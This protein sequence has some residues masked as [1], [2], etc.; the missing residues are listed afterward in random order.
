VERDS[1]TTCALSEEGE[2][3]FFFFLSFLFFFFPYTFTHIYDLNELE[4][5]GQDGKSHMGNNRMRERLAWNGVNQG[6][7]RALAFVFFHQWRERADSFQFVKWSD[8]SFAVNRQKAGLAIYGWQGSFFPRSLSIIVRESNLEHMVHSGR[9]ARSFS[10]LLE[11][12]PCPCLTC[13]LMMLTS[14]SF[15]KNTW[16]E[17]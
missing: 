3:A 6:S 1:V 13:T 7:T 2:L 10:S 17:C 15:F 5:K 9:G 4:M 12:L 16:R 11:D 8:R 14:I